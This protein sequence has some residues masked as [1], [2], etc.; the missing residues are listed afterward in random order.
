MNEKN[1]NCDELIDKFVEIINKLESRGN[2]KDYSLEFLNVIQG[3]P[4]QQLELLTRT[5]IN[6]FVDL[7]DDMMRGCLFSAASLI[8]E[9]KG[10]ITTLKLE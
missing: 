10:I 5:I 9:L 7:G 2:L 1:Q 4:R 6:R 3:I 8:E